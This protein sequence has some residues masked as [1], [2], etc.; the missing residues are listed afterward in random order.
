META[1]F[2]S[3]MSKTIPLEKCLLSVRPLTDAYGEYLNHFNVASRAKCEA[4]QF[5]APGE[6][7]QHKKAYPQFIFT[8]LAATAVKGSQKAQPIM[9]PLSGEAVFEPQA[10][11][12]QPKTQDRKFVINGSVGSTMEIFFTPLAI[13]ALDRLLADVSRCVALIHPSM[14]VQ[15]CYRE[16][17]NK[18]HRQPLTESLFTTSMLNTE[19][20]SNLSFDMNTEKSWLELAAGKRVLYQ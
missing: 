12:V 4:P 8:L 1:S 13:E 19:V 7:A 3:A 6:I 16:C 10:M 2:H 15:T 14:L 20:Y 17:V 18:Q 5:G 11:D 9:E